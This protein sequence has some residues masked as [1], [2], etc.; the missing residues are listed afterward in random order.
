MAPQIA[1]A[2][3][4]A[5]AVATPSAERVV[6]PQRADV[7]EPIVVIKRDYWWAWILAVIAAG[8][9]GFVA[10]YATLGRRVRERFGGVKVY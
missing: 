10:G 2:A 7:A 3:A 5:E 6:E 1:S 9:G 4:P 8:S